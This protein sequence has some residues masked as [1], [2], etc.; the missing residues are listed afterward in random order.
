MALLAERD[1]FNLGKR[2][3]VQTI[4][5]AGERRRRA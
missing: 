4:G 5:R 2:L 3:L 1:V